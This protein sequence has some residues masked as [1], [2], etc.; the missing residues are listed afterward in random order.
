M[1]V[2]LAI[3]SDYN[4]A[5]AQ[6][7]ERAVFINRKLFLCSVIRFEAMTHKKTNTYTYNIRFNKKI[8]CLIS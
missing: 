7:A 2:K 4:T 1:K 8:Q 5:S 3:K 6:T